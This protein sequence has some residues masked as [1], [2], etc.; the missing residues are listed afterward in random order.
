MITDTLCFTNNYTVVIIVTI[1]MLS[2]DA[3]NCCRQ[4]TCSVLTY[5]KLPVIPLH[6]LWTNLRCS[7]EFLSMPM[8][9]TII[10]QLFINHIIISTHISICLDN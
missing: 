1:S 6:F 8:W 4:A 5:H 3:H 9:Q 7:I 2:S 10:G